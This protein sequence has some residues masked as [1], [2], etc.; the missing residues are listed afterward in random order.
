VGRPSDQG[1]PIRG[2]VT[3]THLFL[4]N[5]EPS[6][7]PA[8]NPETGYLDTD[9]S[10]TKTDILE[11]GRKS[12]DNTYWRLCFGL[13]AAQELF[14]LTEDR[15]CARNL[16]TVQSQ[17]NRVKEL[18]ARM[19]KELLEQGDPR[20]KGEGKIFDMYVPT[21]GAGFYEK[22]MRGEKVNAGWVNKTDFE[23]AP[24]KP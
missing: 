20:M 2:I 11:Q 5:Y 1:Y 13:R 19:E 22:Y 8:G 21:A 24:I 10:P 12:R 23:S 7:W 15:D 9:A 6:R 17:S 14:D 4:K 16:A 3:G 18:E